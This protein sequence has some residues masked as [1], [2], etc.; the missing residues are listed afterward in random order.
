MNVK[1]IIEKNKKNMT[2]AQLQ[3]ADFIL[4]N[5]D[6][7]NYLTYSKISNRAGVSEASIIRFLRFLGFQSI[8]DFKERVKENI[9]RK[10][11]PSIRMKDT[12]ERI[13][14]KENICENLLN[15]DRAM[16]DEI[17]EN[18]SQDTIKKA[19]KIISKARRIYVIGFGI[20]RGI[21]D[22]LDFR[23][24]RMGYP[25]TTITIGGAEVV[26][27]LFSANEKDVIIAIGFFR[28]HKEIGIS[29]D[30]AH[31]KN[32]PVISITDSFSSP[33]A[34]GA[35]VVLHAR[36]G[37]KEFITSLVAPMAVANIITLTLVMEDKEKSIHSFHELEGM[38][39]KY[40][41]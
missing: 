41:L 24:N 18:L 27:K 30:I 36:R 19:G 8:S 20:S 15:I 14:K 26:E 37:P 38:K 1:A 28:P 39:D 6:D 35:A 10:T 33:L 23:L 11:L 2:N 17:Q 25:V 31:E 21:V 12:V 5:F 4:D 34:R 29:F 16:L 40:N 3:L 22:F 13:E 7:I 9:K 32:I